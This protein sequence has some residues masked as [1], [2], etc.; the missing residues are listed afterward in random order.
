M[1]F[2]IFPNQQEELKSMPETGMGYQLIQARFAEESS[3]KEL[4]VLNEQLVVENNEEKKGYLKEVFSKSFALS[5]ENVQ[6]RE[7]KDI[8]L[9]NETR[10]FKST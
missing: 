5:V 8:M 1:I 10:T 3:P 9:V 7:L 6:Y 4:I 2:K